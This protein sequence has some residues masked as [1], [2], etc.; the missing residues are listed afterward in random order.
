MKNLTSKQLK[1]A[2]KKI[3]SSTDLENLWTK[4]YPILK[5]NVF[6]GTK[7]CEENIT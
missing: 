7:P 6:I 4:A 5:F 1:A 3:N 2:G